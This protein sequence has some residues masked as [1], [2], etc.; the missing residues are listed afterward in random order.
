MENNKRDAEIKHNKIKQDFVVD[1]KAA[2]VINP[3]IEESCFDGSEKNVKLKN[4]FAKNKT[5]KKK[6]KSWVNEHVKNIN[7]ADAFLDQL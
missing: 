4:I 1:L 5:I 3:S 2:L 7:E 6:Y